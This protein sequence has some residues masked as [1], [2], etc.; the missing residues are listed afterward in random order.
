MSAQAPE[1][2]QQ[3]FVERVGDSFRSGYERARNVAPY[4]AAVLMTAATAALAP[5]VGAADGEPQRPAP[6]FEPGT[7]VGKTSQTCPSPAAD[8]G[9]C[10]EG[11]KMPV[12]FTATPNKIIN[13]HTAVTATCYSGSRKIG[14]GTFSVDVKQAKLDKRHTFSVARLENPGTAQTGATGR[15]HGIKAEGDVGFSVH[16]N[17][18]GERSNDDKTLCLSDYIIW[19]TKL[20]PEL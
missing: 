18:E 1:A 6:T 13:F 11:E 17:D 15:L 7:Y 4:A 9:L 19:K 14:N 12:S 16:L 2:I 8:V 5:E 10:V 3:N 20:V